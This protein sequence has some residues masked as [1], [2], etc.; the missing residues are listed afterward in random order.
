[1]LQNNVWQPILGITG[2]MIY[3]LERKIT[4]LC[5]N[6][7]IIKTDGFVCVIDPGANE[8][9]SDHIKQVLAELHHDAVCPVLIFLTHC[10]LDHAKEA[11]AICSNDQYRV[12]LA[13]H[14]IGCHILANPDAN[15]SLSWIFRQNM[16]PIDAHFKLFSQTETGYPSH[17]TFILTEKSALDVTTDLIV[18]GA[19]IELTRQCISIGDNINIELYHTPGHSPDS[20]CLQIGE[21]LFIGDILLAASP[22]VAGI[23]GFEQQQL[24][25]SLQ[26]ISW[27]IDNRNARIICSGHGTMLGS[28]IVKKQLRAV[29]EQAKRLRNVTTITRKRAM[30]LKTYAEDMM[31]EAEH[32]FSIIAGRL[33]MIAN[34]LQQLGED[35]KAAEILGIIDM[36]AID[37]MLSDFYQFSQE[38]QQ[39]STFETQ[40]PIMG[41]R[42]ISKL[43]R[44]ISDC[45][46]TNLIDISIL[47]R[48]RLIMNCLLST[49]SGAQREPLETFE[50]INEIIEELLT[51]MKHSVYS[52][53]AIFET[54]DN[55]DAFLNELTRR[56][57]YQPIFDDK[58]L[59]FEADTDLP[60]VLVEREY[61]KDVLTAIMEMLVVNGAHDISIRTSHT[62][63][64]V[65]LDIFASPPDAITKF[66]ER[67]TAF[68]QDQCKM[69][70]GILSFCREPGKEQIT[71]ALPAC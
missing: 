16:S 58:E 3:P 70:D 30:F 48:I 5:S 61:L 18:L 21:I 20:I 38:Y 43:E 15:F 10:H 66:E 53:Q 51:D 52:D 2:A 35:A 31:K 45:R 59:R 40:S 67:K 50:N 39:K 11:A 71:L 55:D 44:L 64:N 24:I 23:Q 12:Y 17:Q 28:D 42:A 56:I 54:L 9:Q 19:D 41:I 8:K 1:M 63:G 14:E 22:M 46:L 34:Y 27:I 62:D 37:A 4:P 47:R 49:I 13:A 36:D 7:Y 6:S 32:L 57:A 25:E 68:F 69:F 29:H 33:Y 65:L 26:K 60:Q